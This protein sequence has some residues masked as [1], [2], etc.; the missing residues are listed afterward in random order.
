[1][2]QRYRGNHPEE[3]RPSEYA[4]AIGFGFLNA[5][6]DLASALQHDEAAL[7][8]T[9][10]IDGHPC[11]RV[12]TPK[13]PSRAGGMVWRFTAWV[14]PKE[15]FLPRR[16]VCRIEPESAQYNELTKHGARTEFNDDRILEFR[17]FAD[18]LLGRD[19]SLPVNLV[20]QSWLCR[21]RIDVRTVAVNSTITPDRFVIKPT[22]G[23]EVVEGEHRHD[24]HAR[25]WLHGGQAAIDERRQESVTKARELSIHTKSRVQEALAL[26]EQD[27]AIDAT[28]RTLWA[29]VWWCIGVCS[30]IAL[31]A[32]LYYARRD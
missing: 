10:S 19:R 14:D 28:P 16:L 29:R 5:D 6:G 15:D 7:V 2:L 27:S 4:Q 32:A 21:Q 12:D 17:R 11:I 8:G 25:R 24:P 22:F 20:C 26:S 30:A 23:T 3:I 9:E 1:M 31:I 13:I 18:P